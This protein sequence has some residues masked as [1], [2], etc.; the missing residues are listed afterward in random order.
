MLTQCPMASEPQ[1]KSQTWIYRE[2]ISPFVYNCVGMER[3]GSCN[4]WIEKPGLI[5][6]YLC[7]RVT[8]DNCITDEMWRIPTE[9][10]YW[11]KDVWYCMW[12][13][14]KPGDKVDLSSVNINGCVMLG[15][16]QQN[17]RLQ[18]QKQADVV[19]TLVIGNRRRLMA[20]TAG[21]GLGPR[22]AI[23]IVD[24]LV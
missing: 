18:R 19:R 14:L 11:W 15:E 21:L 10:G 7:E 24:F 4:N 1:M 9:T 16:R 6:C 5:C 23:R 8:C 12:H 13:E 2:K 20:L 3:C 17:G 22:P